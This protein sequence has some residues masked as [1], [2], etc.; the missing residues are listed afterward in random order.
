MGVGFVRENYLWCSPFNNGH[1]NI[2]R[3]CCHVFFYLCYSH[4]NWIFF[5]RAHDPGWLSS[6]LIPYIDCGCRLLCVLCPELSPWSKDVLM[7]PFFE[8]S[9]TLLLYSFIFVFQRNIE[10]RDGEKNISILTLVELC[11]ECSHN[12]IRFLINVIIAD[13][14]WL[15]ATTGSQPQRPTA[16]Q[17]I[18][19]A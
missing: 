19:Y 5:F 10:Y 2:F 18:L 6:Y 17:Y 14:C 11:S 1:L 9:I 16:I 13:Y 12:S 8:C 15:L 3:Y 7:K 4:L